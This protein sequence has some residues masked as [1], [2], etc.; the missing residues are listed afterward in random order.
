M[1]PFKKIVRRTPVLREIFLFLLRLRTVL[2]YSFRQ[3]REMLTWL[4]RSKEYANFTYDLTYLNKRYLA[5]L[6]AQATGKE[7]H[8][9][10]EYINELESDNDLR[11]HIQASIASSDEKHFADRS[12]NYGRRLGWYAIAR[13]IKPKVIIETGVDKGMGSC[14]LTSALLRNAKEGFLGFYYGT[15]INLHAGYL[16]GG[17]YREYG[18]IL[19]GDSIKSLEK[20]DQVID[21]FINDSDHSAEY[22]EK[23]YLTIVNKLS[24]GAFI[25]GDNSHCNDKLLKFALSTGRKFI[26]FQ[27]KPARHWYPGAGIG[28]AYPD[29]W[30]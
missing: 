15:D 26:F 17:I 27:E 20:F 6:I 24:P 5:S 3:S 25:L 8:Q 7:Y 2:D 28:I 19:Y 1:K 4:W 9:I 12:V 23:E 18:N 29:A 21:L 13:A 11:C 30:H 14:V 16:L 22:E 10:E